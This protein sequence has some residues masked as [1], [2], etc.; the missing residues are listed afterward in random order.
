MQ[1]FTEYECS[2]NLE[3]WSSG[4]EICTGLLW[5]ESHAS[6]LSLNLI[7]Q[8]SEGVAESGMAKSVCFSHKVFHVHSTTYM[9]K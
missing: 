2:D 6:F 1:Y 7:W 3:A 9:C 8:L 4:G 5:R